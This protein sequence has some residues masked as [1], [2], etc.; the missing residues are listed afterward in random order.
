MCRSKPRVSTALNTE[1]A[2]SESD[3]TDQALLATAQFDVDSAHSGSEL[4][5]ITE[6]VAVDEG[7]DYAIIRIQMPKKRAPMS[8]DWSP[9]NL[10]PGDM[11][12][13]NIIQHPNG[14]PKKIAIRNNL[15]TAAPSQQLRY[16]T[17]TLGGSSGAPVLNDTWRVVGI[18]RGSIGTKVLTFNR[19]GE[20]GYTNGCD[21]QLIASG[22]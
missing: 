14:Q 6:V 13:L 15:A 5:K 1:P 16:F 19:Y 20:S 2:A 12:P 18:H 8:V 11:V 7:L 3:F 4:I 17:A 21:I 22:P 9:F 10:K